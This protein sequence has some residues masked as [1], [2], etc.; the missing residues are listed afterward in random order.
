MH[1][2]RRL[3]RVVIALGGRLAGCLPLSHRYDLEKYPDLKGKGVRSAL[4]AGNEQATWP[5]RR[6]DNGISGHFEAGKRNA[7]ADRAPTRRECLHQACR[8]Q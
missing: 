5:K 7:E 8:D 1:S 4:R 2:C 3:T 6:T